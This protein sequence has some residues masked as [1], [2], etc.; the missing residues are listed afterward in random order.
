M[1]PAGLKPEIDFDAFSAVDIRAGTIERV[2]EVPGSDKLLRL[3]VDFGDRRRRILSG[4]KQERAN[5]QALA[6]RQALFV[7]NLRPR[8][9]AGE[10]SGGMLPDLGYAVGLRPAPLAQPEEPVPN[11]TRA[12]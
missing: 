11:G 4:I 8:R 3:I 10:I 12:G 5:P 1:T 6:G 9:M 2:E 7:V